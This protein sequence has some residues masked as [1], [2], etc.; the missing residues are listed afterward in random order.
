MRK[1]YA[2]DMTVSQRL[3]VAS[4]TPHLTPFS[5]RLPNDKWTDTLKAQDQIQLR[6]FLQ[7]HWSERTVEQEQ[8]WEQ[9]QE[10]GHKQPITIGCV[11]Q[12]TRTRRWSCSLDLPD[13]LVE[14]IL[15]IHLAQSMEH[16]AEM[17][18][19]AARARLVCQQFRRTTNAAIRCMLTTVAVAARSLLG[20]CPREPAEVQPVVRAA[21][22]TLRHALMLHPGRWHSYARRRLVVEKRDGTPFDQATRVCPRHRCA[23][24][25]GIGI[26]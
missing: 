3:F 21:G 9:E 8:K 2:K 6:R 13:D 17:H 25:W 5:S 7:R 23:L 16:V 19:A 14:R 4:L 26:A 10:K 20:S 24:L 1:L 22:L 15:S 12:R 11:Q 18:E